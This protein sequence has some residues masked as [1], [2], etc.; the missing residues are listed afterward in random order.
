MFFFYWWVRACLLIYLLI[1]LLIDLFTYWF[2][3][4][5]FI[6]LFI[7]LLAYV[8]IYLLTYLLTY[9]FTCLLNW[10]TDISTDD[11][12][13]QMPQKHDC[14]CLLDLLI[15]WYNFINWFLF[16]W[17]ILLLKQPVI[18]SGEDKRNTYVDTTK[19]RYSIQRHPYVIIKMHVLK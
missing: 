19:K 9:L 14:T 18:F 1:Y 4:L 16:C 5:L 13:L 10:F 6:Y 2:T 7:Y 17:E 12:K 8:F 15:Y 11:V 3:Y